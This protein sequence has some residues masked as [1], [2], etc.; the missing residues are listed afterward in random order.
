MSHFVECDAG[1]INLDHVARIREVREK[2]TDRARRNLIFEN[3][4]GTE[5]G[6]QTWATCDLEEMAPIVPAASGASA[7]I[8]WTFADSGDHDARPDTV[9]FDHVPVVAWR[10]VH[11]GAIPVLLQATTSSEIVLI[12]LPDGRLCL[13]EDAVY[14]GLEEA[15]RCL[16]LRAQGDWD[17]QHA[18]TKQK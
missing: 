2:N 17:R 6:R 15:K 12:P 18:E 3:A 4:D 10:V 11:G 8:V 1:W 5:M 7:I 13:P 16:L 14:E 9:L